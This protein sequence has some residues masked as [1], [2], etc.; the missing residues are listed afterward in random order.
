MQV[1]VPNGMHLAVYTYIHGLY[2]HTGRF[3]DRRE[4]TVGRLLAPSQF[5]MIAAVSPMH[6]VH[7]R[8][9]SAVIAVFHYTNY[10]MLL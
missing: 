3:M 1:I 9:G 7:A 6:W 5:H 8:C 4:W 2:T 10:F